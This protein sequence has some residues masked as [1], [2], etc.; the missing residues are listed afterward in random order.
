MTTTNTHTDPKTA[1]ADTERRLAEAWQEYTDGADL[2]EST[3]A[4]LLDTY[5][6]LVTDGCYEESPID[7]AVWIVADAQ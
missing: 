1:T 2:T 3:L 5:R 6:R 4:D 7:E